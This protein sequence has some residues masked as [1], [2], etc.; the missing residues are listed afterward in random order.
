MLPWLMERGEAPVAEMAARF[1]LSEAELVA[2]LELAAMCGLPP[3]VDELIDVF[4]DEGTVYAGVPRVFTKPM[5]LTA[6][7]AFA[8]TA[9][10]R[11]ALQLPGSDPDGPLSRA[12]AKLDAALGKAELEVEMAA[13]PESDRLVAAAGAGEVMAIR[14]WS[15]ARETTSERRVAPR[16]VFGDRGNW[17]LLADDLDLVAAGVDAE[18]TFRLDRIE[19]MEPT[20]ERVEAREGARPQEWFADDSVA[21]AV[22]RLG[23]QAM[24]VVERYPV[25][26]IE[27][28]EA[29]RA[30]VEL[31]V[32]SE[33][34]LSR[35]LVR[36]GENA[37]VVEPVAWRGLAAATARA[38]LARYGE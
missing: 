9:A 38:V 36:L 33:R 34:W 8:L 3:F 21:T 4:V 31:A 35:L 37:T 10:G 30:D 16:S 29:G 28:R 25:R 27:P 5:R 26:S 24:W 17:Y 18:R 7:E 23:P 19:R 22:L 12:L 1:G 11:A 20:G 15:A 14:Y 13:P 32:A 6:P 2:D